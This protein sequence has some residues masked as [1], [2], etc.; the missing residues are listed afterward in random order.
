MDLG[1]IRQVLVS[2]LRDWVDSHPAADDPQVG[3]AGSPRLLSPR[4]IVLEV[5]KGTEFGEEVLD[6]WAVLVLRSAALEHMLPARREPGDADHRG[7]QSD[8]RELSPA[9]LASKREVG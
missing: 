9:P 7:L 5:E 1:R 4:D 2:E 8:F 3:L 6:Y